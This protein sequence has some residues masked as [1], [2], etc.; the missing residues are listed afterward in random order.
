MHSFGA[1][2]GEQVLDHPPLAGE[3]RIRGAGEILAHPSA[4]PWKCCR[5]RAVGVRRCVCPLAR[6]CLPPAQMC[7]PPL[8]LLPGALSP[9]RPC[10]SRRHR[11]PGTA[12]GS[13]GNSPVPQA[14]S[15]IPAGS[16]SRRLGKKRV[17]E[18]DA[19]RAGLWGGAAGSGSAGTRGA[20]PAH[21][22]PDS[23]ENF[24]KDLPASQM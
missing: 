16:A 3:A 9:L 8:G 20:R 1:R 23:R 21:P 22:S 12:A 15:H 7:L 2:L 18:S 17:G 14:P 6:V 10:G 13:T 19:W 11:A 4:S 24:Q 5:R